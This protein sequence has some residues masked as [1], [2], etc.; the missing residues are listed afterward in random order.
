VLNPAIG[1][2][3]G[4]IVPHERT[5]EQREATAKLPSV[6]AERSVH[7]PDRSPRI[8]VRAP[9]MGRRELELVPNHPLKIP[10]LEQKT[11][12]RVRRKRSD[13]RTYDLFC[14]GVPPDALPVGHWT[15]LARIV[16]GT[17]IT[18]RGGAVPGPF[19]NRAPAERG[20]LQRWLH[21][22]V[23]LRNNPWKDPATRDL[24]VYLP[25]GWDGQPLPA[26]LVLA[27]YTATGEKL[28]ARGFFEPSIVTRFDDLIA[29]GCPPFVAVLPDGMSS[30]GGT[31]YI[32]SPGIGDYTTYFADEVTEAVER[33][34]PVARWVVVGRSSGGFGA[35]HLAMSR[36]GRFDGVACHSG[37]LGFDLCYLS[38]FV[39]A[40]CTLEGAGGIR[41]F[42]ER[43]WQKEELTGSEIV[44]LSLLCAAAAYG[45]GTPERAEPYFPAELPFDPTTG[46]VR[47]DVLAKWQSFD[48]LQRVTREANALKQLSTLYI[49]VGDRDEY[50]LQFGARRL[51]AALTNLKV[52]FELC[53]FSGGHRGTAG[54][55]A[56]SI[57]KLVV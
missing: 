8:G 23:A 31:Q 28:L 13:E 32:D 54:R 11:D 29:S 52:P 12:D 38:E 42:L 15:S 27:P 25:P 3:G 22:S 33:K 26:V 2:V 45:D 24:Y 55:I 7:R 9:Q 43:A 16:T 36:P 14:S 49:D 51:G 34:L 46:A 1:D 50:G 48:V 18:A 20:T 39:P 35:L 5:P 21:E 37:D 56:Q 44:T 41:G 19:P 53:T 57:P 4:D 47:F 10:P 17:V 30:L 6:D 40:L